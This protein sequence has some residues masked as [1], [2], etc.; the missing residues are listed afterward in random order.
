MST[1]YVSDYLK[2]ALLKVRFLHLASWGGR[3]R[4]VV[5]FTR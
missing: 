1:F 2:L 3:R 5:Q 4:K